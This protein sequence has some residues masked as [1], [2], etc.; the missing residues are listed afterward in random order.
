MT[1]VIK[2]LAIVYGLAEHRPG[3]L[4]APPPPPER[5]EWGPWL[6]ETAGLGLAE[7]TAID[8]IPAITTR[9][10]L[11]VHHQEYDPRPPTWSQAEIL[12]RWRRR[13]DAWLDHEYLAWCEFLAHY[14]APEEA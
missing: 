10:A 3:S 12:A 2:G 6:P 1:G 8:G 13:M 4:L 14:P 7:I 11:E 9:R 5:G